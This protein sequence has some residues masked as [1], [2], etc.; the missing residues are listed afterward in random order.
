ML[1]GS[2]IVDGRLDRAELLYRR[3][4]EQD[5]TVS[6]THVRL[7]GVYELLGQPEAAASEYRTAISLDPSAAHA[8]LHLG[9]IVGNQ[10][11]PENATA[12][13]R[14]AIEA[15]PAYLQAHQLL[16]YSLALSG[17]DGW[18]DAHRNAWKLDHGPQQP[19]PAPGEILL[20]MGP[21]SAA[22][23][24]FAERVDAQ[25][26]DPTALLGFARAL[27][28]TARERGPESASRELNAAL[29]ISSQVASAQPKLGAAHRALADALFTA[30]RLVEARREYAETIRIEPK[31]ATDHL[32]YASV[33]LA[34]GN[35]AEAARELRRA[36]A[37]DPILTEAY[38][39]LGSLLG[40]QGNAVKAK[41][42]LAR[43]AQLRGFA[44]PA[45]LP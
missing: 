9:I 16:G 40:R 10:G 29:Q 7:G 39:Q 35:Q 3:S 38:Q 4:I 23:S 44:I 1:G 25:S 36:I 6:E 20:D 22:L 19:F 42:Y 26:K 18:I 14:K 28:Q 30:G 12:Y 17:E 13:F 21:S 11:Q 45:S 33:L 5:P 32:A 41:R 34:G 43:A 27:T 15:W 2:A 37:L 8:Y 24:W 31:R